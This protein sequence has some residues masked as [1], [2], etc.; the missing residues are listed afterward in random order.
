MVIEFNKEELIQVEKIKSKYPQPKAAIMA[1]LWLAQK[2]FGWI[3]DDVKK[4]IGELLGLSYSHV[5]GVASFYTM[6]FKKP[7]GK[8][9][10]QV[11]TNVSCM[12]LGGEELYSHISNKLGIGHNQRTDDGKFS[13]EEVECMGACGGAPMLAINE[14]YHEFVNIN[15]VDKLIDS[16]K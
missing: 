14:D 16:L 10:L 6:Y 3:S 12:L 1:V 5:H 13:L 4:Y 9:H 7:M 15:E 8:Y 2:K 11:C